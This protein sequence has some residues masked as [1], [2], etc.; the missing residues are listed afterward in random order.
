MTAC[1]PKCFPRCELPDYVE[2]PN[3]PLNSRLE[4]K[5]A[6][7]ACEGLSDNRAVVVN[8]LS[9]FENSTVLFIFEKRKHIFVYWLREGVSS[10]CMC[11]CFHGERPVVAYSYD[12]VIS[13]PTGQWWC[14][15]WTAAMKPP[16]EIHNIKLSYSNF[17]LNLSTKDIHPQYVS[18]SLC[19]QTSAQ[20][21]VNPRGCVVTCLSGPGCWGL[22][23]FTKLM[24][25]KQMLKPI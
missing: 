7:R 8:E 23:L 11:C 6:S 18:V 19:L 16:G 17:V 22:T 24:S 4:L 21:P 2:H 13:G 1:L 12:P 5:M 3:N 20:C 10:Y 25:W 15:S 14:V 9:M